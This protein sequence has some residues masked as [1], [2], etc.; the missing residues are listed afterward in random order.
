VSA[1]RLA[2]ILR[3]YWP[4]LCNLRGIS[5]ASMSL[6]LDAVMNGIVIKQP[7][8]SQEFAGTC[9]YGYIHMK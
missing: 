7:R 8:T 3:H 2:E 4:I 1:K 6:D 9:V 5:V